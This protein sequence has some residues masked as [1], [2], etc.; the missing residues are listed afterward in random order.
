MGGKVNSTRGPLTLALVAAALNYPQASTQRCG[1]L[2]TLPQVMNRI[3]GIEF[4][5]YTKGGLSVGY[6]IALGGK[7]GTGKTTIA[8]LLIRYMIKRGMKPILAVDA[9]SNSNL[10]DVLGVPLSST[11]GDAREQMKTD[12][13]SGMTKDIFM[14]MKVEEALVEGDGFD[15]VAMGNPEGAG[16]YC[17]A[18]NL[19]SS[20]MDRLVKN[21]DYMVVDNEAGMEHF[22]RLTQKDID[23]LLLV[24]DPSRRGLTAACRIADLVKSLPIRVSEAVLLVNQVQDSPDGWPREVEDHF[25]ADHIVVLPEDQLLAAFDREGKPTITLPDDAPVVKATEAL[26]ERLLGRSS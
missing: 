1:L 4:E 20:L 16:C 22:S 26:F 19:L 23:L 8:G 7:G 21:Y 12:V 13:P 24:S 11:L 5:P 10:N 3:G 14:E 2:L 25:D 6:T 9:D 15:L 18:N 17:A